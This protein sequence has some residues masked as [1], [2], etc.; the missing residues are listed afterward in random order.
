MATEVTRR[1][2]DYEITVDGKH[3]G[4]AAFTERPDA[5]VF[6]HTEIADGFEGK[7]I[8]SQLAQAALDDVRRRGL[9][10]VPHCPFIKGWIDR[11][12]DYRDLVAS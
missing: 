11:H 2:S 5:V 6:T 3:A 1:A 12:P 8:G 4:L 7:G 10:A 9:S